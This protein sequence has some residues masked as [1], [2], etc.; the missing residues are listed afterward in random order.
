M[1]VMIIRKAFHFRIYPSAPQVA[2]MAEWEGA[3][4]WLW[5]LALEQRLMGLRRTDKRYP[6]AFDQINEL[7]DLRAEHRIQDPTQTCL[8]QEK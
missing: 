4:R 3:L 1:M 6:T 8:K 7:T 2:R 5:N